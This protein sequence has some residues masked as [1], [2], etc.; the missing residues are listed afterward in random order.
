MLLFNKLTEKH[1][2]EVTEYNNTD[3]LLEMVSTMFSYANCP[4]P[5]E[6]LELYLLIFGKCAVFLNDNKKLTV[7]FCSFVGTLDSYGRGKDLIC[8]TENGESYSFDDWET[9]DK[10]VVIFNNKY[11]SPDLNIG[12]TS[13]FLSETDKSLR[14]AIVNTRFSKVLRAGNEMQKTLLEKAVDNNENGKP[15]V[16]VSSNILED[17]NQNLSVDLTNPEQSDKLQYLSKL[18]TDILRRFFNLYG[19]STQGID[20]VAQMTKEEVQNGSNASFIIPCD[21][22]EE[23]VKGITRVN[24]VFGTD[25]KVDFSECWKNEYK[26]VKGEVKND[27]D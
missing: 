9:S 25:I 14:N 11:H 20:K 21:R 7:S 16:V 19:M 12:I 24:N 13:D 4:F 6:F 22:L 15:Q 8:T 18:H 23:R 27:T 5:S 1:K 17:E 2:Q 10:V 3:I 26:K